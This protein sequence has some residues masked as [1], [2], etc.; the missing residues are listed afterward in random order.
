MRK[1]AKDKDSKSKRDTEKSRVGEKQHR[2]TARKTE[3][4]T[5]T[6]T[7]QQRTRQP[8]SHTHRK[9]DR[10]IAAR[11]RQWR[12]ETEGDPQHYLQHHGRQLGELDPASFSIGM[13][14]GH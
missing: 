13:H 5:D 11:Q 1:Q 9:T 2:D 3:R 14:L 10:D 6:Q 12:R 4:G 8:P 7:D